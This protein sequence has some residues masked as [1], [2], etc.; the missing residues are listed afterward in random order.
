MPPM[1]N[2]MIDFFEQELQRFNPLAKTIAV[3]QPMFDE[4]IDACRVIGDASNGYPGPHWMLDGKIKVL[5][6]KSLTGT[7]F[8]ILER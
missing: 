2:P 1:Q 6:D 3:S 4:F 5:V 7:K 8:R